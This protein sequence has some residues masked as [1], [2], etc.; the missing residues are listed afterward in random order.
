[1]KKTLPLLL[2]L[3]MLPSALTAQIRHT[4]IPYED[5]ADFS[6]RK[7]T[8]SIV[9]IGDVMMHGP[10]SK[11]AFRLYSESHPG[12]NPNN[13]AH[14][15]FSTFFMHLKD[16]FQAADLAICN[17]EFPLAGAPYTGYPAFSAPDSYA[18]YIVSCG[19]DVLL[20]ANNHILDK[21]SAG[22]RRTIRTYDA[23]EASS[24]VVYTGISKDSAD[25]DARYPAIVIVKG[26]KIAILNFTYGTNAGSD[27]RWP[28]VNLTHKDDILKAIGRAKEQNADLIIAIPHWGTEYQQRHSAQQGD[29][30]RWMAARGVDLIVGHH[31]HVVQ[32]FELITVTRD[33]GEIHQVPVLYSLGNAVS[34]QNDLITRLE[35][36]A[37]FKVAVHGMDKKLLPEPEITFLWC[38]KPRMVEDSYS[39]LPVKD[40]IE[41]K[42]EWRIQ[43]DYTNMVETYKNVKK[44]TGIED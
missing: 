31:P 12:A 21:G 40:F 37:E 6:F 33:D 39:V 14:Y 7:D 11:D 8:V 30:A 26:V 2:L 22:L 3:A 44:K 18:D 15:D 24:E 29:L 25:D 13:S 27:S 5:F 32:D 9:L 23:I 19:F 28:K 42:D 1:M 20:A 16:R 38:T 36:M 4:W 43:S 35:A 41:K 17:M 34:N 10:Q